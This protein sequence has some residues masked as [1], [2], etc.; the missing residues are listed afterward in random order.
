[1]KKII[2]LGILLLS[3]GFG[4]W[5]F[6]FNTHQE[7][8]EK[9]PRKGPRYFEFIRQLKG[10]APV[11][12]VNRW[13]RSDRFSKRSGQ[14]L[15]SIEEMGP[16]NV[17][18]RTRAVLIDRSN[19]NRIFVGG[20]SG[21]LWVSDNA[22]QSWNKI[23]D[24]AVSLNISHIT[25]NPFNP[26]IIYYCTGEGAGNSSS[27]P[28]AGI[29]KSTDHGQTFV[30]L[31]AS[32]GGNFDYSWRIEHSLVDSNTFFV[33][34]NN[35]GLFRSQD[36][37]QSF[38]KVVVT[39]RPIH[40]L[41]VFPDSTVMISIQG[42]A[43]FSSKTGNL[44]SFVLKN[45]GFPALN[46]FGRVELAYCAGQPSVVYAAVSE[47]SNTSLRNVYRSNDQGANWT[48]VAKNPQDEGGNFPF[49]WYC[50]ALHVKQDD[51]NT[52]VIG[53]V[54]VRVSTNGGNNWESV[55][56]SHAD[57]HT[58]VAHPSKPN[59]VY[60]GNDGGLFEYDWSTIEDEF[61]N[62][63]YGLNITQFYAG[64]F[65]PNGLNIITGAQ[66]NGTNYTFAG[67]DTFKKL[68]GAD[69][70]YTQINQQDPS[71]AY[72]SYQNG[73][74]FRVDNF[75]SK[76]PALTK[77]TYNFDGDQDE[78]IDDGAWFIHPFDINPQNGEQV[79][80]PTKRRLYVSHDGGLFFEPVTNTMNAGNQQE[81]FCVGI[82]NQLSPTVY[83]GGSNGLFYRIKN[84]ATA[85]P[86]H[87][88][89]LRSFTPTNVRSS[90]IG[91]IKVNPV[92]PSVVYI[93]LTNYSATSHIY[94][95]DNADKDTPVFVDISGNL[96][97]NL[98]V[99]WIEVDPASPDSVLFAATDFGLYYTTD[100]G[101]TWFKEEGIPNV[102][103]DMIRLRMS[104]RRLFI[105]THGRGAFT[106]RVT[107]YGKAIPPHS[108][109]SVEEVEKER[110]MVFP[111]PAKDDVQLRWTTLAGTEPKRVEIVDQK[112]RTV[113]SKTVLPGE[114]INTSSLGT[115]VYYIRAEGL[116]TEKL[117]IL[118]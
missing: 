73:N 25:Q 44:N 45:G 34:T 42:H 113:L 67:N 104:D 47:S 24:Q 6:A 114:R 110:P 49:T 108:T 18:G 9:G 40:D 91:S 48:A 41:E 62:L 55:E 94:R 61:E 20:I 14:V 109:V 76:T 22:G 32:V 17:G 37:G 98:P 30:Q 23:N 97:A 81:V 101:Q 70:S 35:L 58:M 92:N 3:L 8:P 10:Q 16:F 46:T 115:G 118:K 19:S 71:I 56:N 65:G 29:F 88:K 117:L 77:L 13:N 64:A 21:G 31:P 2:P 82:S 83:V 93:G 12:V 80:F 33:A 69:G 102:V 95:V 43:V 60:I 27:A 89:N 4:L 51:P 106:A 99:N 28:G 63:N 59:K 96:P 85:T 54:N 75:G 57:Y 39:A 50:L 11:D 15:D 1:M 90:F 116:S 111:N 52:V 79:Y 53:S 105:Y 26:D 36:G 86:G 5:H 72:L 68:Y 87:E 66:D 7:E 103:I 84:A 112:G 74:V 100:A 78:E 107:P 38:E